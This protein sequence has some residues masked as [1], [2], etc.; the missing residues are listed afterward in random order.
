MKK[1]LISL[2]ERQIKVL[3][4]SAKKLGI[5][6]SEFLRRFLDKM[7]EMKEKKKSENNKN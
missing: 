5:N 4:E 7:I 2:T 6:R 3:D 1:I